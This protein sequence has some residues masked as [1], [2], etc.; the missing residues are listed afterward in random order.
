MG[1]F[2]SGHPGWHGGYRRGG[3]RILWFAL[4][5]VAATWHFKAKEHTHRD[6]FGCTW[7]HRRE[8]EALRA[9]G[10]GE[11][12]PRELEALRASPSPERE[13]W[14]FSA[15]WGQPAA[16]TSLPPPS[17][18]EP[19]AV[20]S[21]SASLPPAFADLNK[22]QQEGWTR[23]DAIKAAE[24]AADRWAAEQERL[25]QLTKQ[26]EEKVRHSRLILFQPLLTSL[27]NY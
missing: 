16:D 2:H 9:A 3:S 4:G 20:P 21:A 25:H 5:A 19:L 10:A 27:P 18:L 8:L 6:G 22:F 24:A 11:A 12:P 15:R 1:H 14:R 17:A 23:E 13:R 26:A 7:Q